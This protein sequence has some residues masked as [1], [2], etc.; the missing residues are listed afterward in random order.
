MKGKEEA[1]KVRGIE[2]RGIEGRKRT[3]GRGGGLREGGKEGDREGTVKSVM[4]RALKVARPP[5][6]MHSGKSRKLLFF[7]NRATSDVKRRRRS[8]IWEGLS[9][10]QRSRRSQRIFENRPVFT[11]LCVDYGG[12][13]FGPPCILTLMSYTVLLLVACPDY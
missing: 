1:E 2:R 4:P 13:L 9:H 12:L 8:Q 6:L 11:T 5:L 7:F 10:P 3:E